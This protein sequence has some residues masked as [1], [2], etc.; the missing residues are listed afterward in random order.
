M[1]RTNVVV[2]Q[3]SNR[4]QPAPAS[5]GKSPSAGREIAERLGGPAMALTLDRACRW[6]GLHL[7]DLAPAPP[8]PPPGS[9]M[10]APGPGAAFLARVARGE[11]SAL[12]ELGVLIITRPSMFDPAAEAIV[13]MAV[14]SALEAGGVEFADVLMNQ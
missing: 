10:P 4:R 2:T 5:S 14:G 3:P 8:P 13:G 6:D 11:S 9:L 1:T 7:P 12:R